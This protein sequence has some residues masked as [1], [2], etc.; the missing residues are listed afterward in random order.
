MNK[1]KTKITVD[2][3]III[4]FGLLGVTALFIAMFWHPK[5]QTGYPMMDEIYTNSY[6]DVE[7]R[8]FKVSENELIAGNRKK[9]E[10]TADAANLN[11]TEN[12][13]KY[14]PVE[15]MPIGSYIDVTADVDTVV[16]GIAGFNEVNIK[17]VKEIGDIQGGRDADKQRN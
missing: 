13:F 9:E 12:S 14:L 11:V 1:K 3:I 2:T 16:G 10:L 17:K 5:A 6:Q 4:L 15:D 7:L 8:V